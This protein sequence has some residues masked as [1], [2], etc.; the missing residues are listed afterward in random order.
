MNEA[1]R[2]EIRQRRQRGDTCKAIAQDYG[3]TASAVWRATGAMGYNYKAQAAR[4]GQVLGHGVL[5]GHWGEVWAL[6]QLGCPLAQI[7]SRFG[8]SETA[9]SSCL[10]K[11]KAQGW[12]RLTLAAAIEG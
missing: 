4:R 2:Q 1:T 12:Q 8:V 6:R 3:L 10:R 11:Y 7:A 9:I 5:A